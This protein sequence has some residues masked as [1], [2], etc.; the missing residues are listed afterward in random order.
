MS[1]TEIKKTAKT[2]INPTRAEDYPE[3][4]QQVIKA[5]E[6]AEVS[7]V[8]GCMTIRPWVYA[9]WKNIQRILDEQLKATGHKNLY[10][11]LLIPAG[12]LE[13][14]AK[15]I[16]GFAKECAVVTHAKLAINEDGKLVPANPLEEPY[17]IR[18]T[19]ETIIGEAFSR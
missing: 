11:P 19:S 9:I 18:P 13:K 3:W 15:H 7:P 10:F 8:R 12:F 2:A 1:S 14:E 4:Y 17:V 6:L 5:A 16:E